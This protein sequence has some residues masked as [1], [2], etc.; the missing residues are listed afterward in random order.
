MNNQHWL[1][2]WTRRRQVL[3]GIALG[4]LAL[5]GTLGLRLVRGPSKTS[6]SVEQTVERARLAASN[7]SGEAR[8]AIPAARLSGNAGSGPAAHVPAS[9]E[10]RPEPS[11]YTRQLVAGL[12]NLDLSNGPIAQDQAAQWKRTL[13]TLTDQGAAAVPAIREFLARNWEQDFSGSD[14]ASLLGQSSLRS[15]MV[16]A[17][18]QIGGPEG[19]DALV[20]TL[21]STTLPS[22]ISQLA[23]ALEGQAPGQY[24]QETINAIGEVLNMASNDQLPNDWD[25]GTL[26]KLVQTYGDSTT[27]GAL[28]Q[29]DGPFKYY[30]TMALAGMESGEGVGALIHEA[31]DTTKV[32][33]RPF[34]FQ[35]LAQVAAQYPDAGVALLE[36]VKANQVPESAWQLIA[37]GLAGDQYLIGQPPAP[38]PD[39]STAGE[40]IPGLKTYHIASGN[41]NFY[42]V[43]L[44]PDSHVQERVALI[45]QLLA[46]TPNPVARQAL[47]S[48]RSTLTQTA[49]N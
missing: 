41:Q 45:D 14:A 27:A 39:P 26:F 5:A 47:Q 19:I 29:L 18:A 30:A 13:Q 12:T 33:E 9:L 35:M 16:N 20:D 48:A 8:P 21:R 49:A 46:A 4:F 42:S 40:L 32:G 1:K 7:D 43:P 3:A 38:S 31:Q 24:R 17:L 10:A 15:A 34:A 36:Q 37:T 6:H 22:E 28:E 44:M 2:S 25:V 23:Q 11:P